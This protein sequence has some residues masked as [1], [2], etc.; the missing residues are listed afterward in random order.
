M[1]PVIGKFKSNGLAEAKSLVGSLYVRV[2]S[3]ITVT[4]TKIESV[5]WARQG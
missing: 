1:V 2:V 5:G 3:F 4:L